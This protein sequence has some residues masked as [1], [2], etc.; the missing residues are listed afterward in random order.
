MK[1][2]FEYLNESLLNEQLINEDFSSSILREIKDQFNDRIKDHH[3]KNALSKYSSNDISSTFKKIFGSSCGIAWDKITDD[4]FKKYSKSDEEG[5]KLAKRI[6]SER[7]NSFNGMILLLTDPDRSRFIGKYIGALISIGG[8]HMYFSFNTTYQISSS[9]I[10]PSEVESFLTKEF[11]II[12]L[13]NFLTYEKTRDRR[14]SQYGTFNLFNDPDDREKEFANMIKNNRERYKQYVAKVKAQKDADDG[15][16]EKVNEYVNKILE[17]ATNMSKNPMKYAKF[18]YE[19]GYLID[20]LQ[21]ER[22]WNSNGNRGKGYYSGTDGLLLVYKEYIKSKLAQAK[23]N[24][25][26]FERDS[27][28]NAKKKLEQIFK[29]IDDKLEKFKEVA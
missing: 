22:T 4:D 28:N 21:D 12:D 14:N 11:Y 17:V 19:V 26:S 13:R 29:T 27:Y 20:L 3:E 16:S 25:Y 7:S 2:I 18:E 8:G 5:V 6:C 9:F 15:M 23:G 10:K 24:S 1:S